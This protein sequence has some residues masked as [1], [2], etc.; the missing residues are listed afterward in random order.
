MAERD[1]IQE[2]KDYI[3]ALGYGKED[4]QWIGGRDFTIPI[5]NFWNSKPQMYD[6]GYGTQEVAPDL[7]IAF[8]DHTWIQRE[9][10]D[11]SEWWEYYRYPL[12]PL[13]IESV[14]KFV[15]DR[16]EHSLAAI[17]HVK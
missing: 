2:T 14:N 1:I 16:Y 6:S 10:Y 5:N 13:R 9:E 7:I 4:I 3:D 17:N 15:A 11:G 8:K 12:M